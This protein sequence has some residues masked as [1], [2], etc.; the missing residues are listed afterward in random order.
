[1][2]SKRIKEN[3]PVK[4]PGRTLVGV[5]VPHPLLEALDRA[6]SI[7]D[8]DRSKFIRRAIRNSVPSPR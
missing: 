3:Q 4:R 2:P 1:M 7:Q 8:L 5:W 6:A